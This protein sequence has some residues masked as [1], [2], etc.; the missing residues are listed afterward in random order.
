MAVFHARLTDEE[1]SLD[2]RTLETALRHGRCWS[3]L[4]PHRARH[5]TNDG[6][7]TRCGKTLGDDYKRLNEYLAQ[8]HPPCKRCLAEEGKANG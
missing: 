1:K 2:W 7:T 5:I 8:F 3:S 6:K 4:R